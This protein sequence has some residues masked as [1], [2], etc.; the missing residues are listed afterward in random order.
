[1]IGVSSMDKLI[2]VIIPCY[3]VEQYITRCIKSLINQT[4]GMEKLELIF[5]ND[6]SPDN[7]INI[8]LEYEKLYPSSMIVIDSKVNMKQGGAK[9]LG[10]NYASADYVCFVD[11]DDWVE[12]TI[13]EKL[14]TNAIKYDCDI[15][16]SRFKNVSR[17]GIPMGRTGED[18]KFVIVENNIQRKILL[19][20]GIGSCLG[21]LYKK[22]FLINNN[23]KYL[24][25]IT[26]EDNYMNYLTTIYVEKI[27]FLEEYLYY[28]FDNSQ[29]TVARKD[30]PHHY[31]RL[32]SECMKI[33]ELKS[34]KLFET[35]HDEI[36]FNF[37]T[38]FYLNSLNIFFTRFT[39][40]QVDIFQY[41]KETVVSLFPHYKK[42]PYLTY[43]PEVYH[44][45]LKT[46]DTNVS[47]DDWIQIASAYNELNLC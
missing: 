15:V 29:S 23:I 20:N 14:Y 24:E 35:Y 37:I 16:S 1:M 33:E 27:Y 46:I 39:T 13:F 8:L 31:D 11:S 25:R 47:E 10:L 2:S 42:N 21:K 28:Y 32:I 36:E 38:L 26:Y 22:E 43:V 9:N 12:Q 30:S 45:L 34:R 40:I 7:T 4:I 44:I 41:M 18:D 17:E 6:A 5:V 19:I 3:N